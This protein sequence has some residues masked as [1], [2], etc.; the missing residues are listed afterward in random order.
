MI[1]TF[2][3]RIDAYEKGEMTEHEELEF[4]Q[5]LVDSGMAWHLQGHYGRHAAHLLEAG[6][7]SSTGEGKNEIK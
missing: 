7:I 4:F 6:V 1:S 5:A 3:D 2:L